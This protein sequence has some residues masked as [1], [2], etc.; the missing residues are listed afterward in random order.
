[1]F[2]AQQ[3]RAALWTEALLLAAIIGVID[4]G[5]TNEVNLAIFQLLP[6]MFATWY[7]SRRAGIAITLMIL[8]T[9]IAGD[10]IS[11]VQFSSPLIPY[12]NG[13]V[14]LAFFLIVITLTWLMRDAKSQA[15]ELSRTD[16]LTGVANGRSFSDRC[17]LELNRLQR[18]GRPVTLAYVDLDQFKLI[19]DT[20]GHA[21]G[22]RLL[23]AVASAVSERIR[24]TDHVARLG[25]DE[26]AVL[27]P[28]TGRDSAPGV[29]A[30]IESA[31]RHSVS[32]EWGVGCTIG[33]VTFE[34]VPVS[35]D[36][37]V[38][39]TDNLMYQGKREGRG[40]IVHRSW[41]AEGDGET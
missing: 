9:W 17:A 16:A 6:V 32:E 15:L 31:V 4:F 14:R 11:G 28:E 13:F 12:W 41:P 1:M 10:I 26:F 22:D 33:A 36:F 21:E 40:R 34:E 29:L 20:R 2:L 8:A 5:V 24:S 18:T 27:L 35:V 39:V 7:I 25:G 19:N 30:D 23:Q 3:S 37:M 38:R